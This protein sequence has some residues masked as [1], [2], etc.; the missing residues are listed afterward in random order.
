MTTLA[1]LTPNFRTVRLLL[2]REKGHP[3]GEQD[4]GYDILVPLDNKGQLIP[5][6]GSRT[7]NSAGSASSA[8][9]RKTASAACAASPAVN[10]ISTMPKATATTKSASASPTN[11]S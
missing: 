2:A 11:A 6:N 1:D 9:R 5:T 4:V 10:G 3:G 7:R 8:T